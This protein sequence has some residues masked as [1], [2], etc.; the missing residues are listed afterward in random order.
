[1][2]A[3]VYDRMEKGEIN[4]KELELTEESIFNLKKFPDIGIVRLFGKKENVNLEITEQQQNHSDS[5]PDV[6]EKKSQKSDFENYKLDTDVV[7]YSQRK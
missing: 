5:D 4:K 6:D 1:M 7:S 3:K 2:F